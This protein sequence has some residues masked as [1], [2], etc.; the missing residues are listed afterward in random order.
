M[1]ETNV[2]SDKQIRPPMSHTDHIIKEQPVLDRVDTLIER[3][4][5]EKPTIHEKHVQDVLE[6]RET[7]VEKRIIHP[8]QEVF[9]R[10]EDM[11]ETEGKYI[12][13]WNRNQLIESMREQD[14]HH[15]VQV[16]SEEDIHVH[17]QMPTVI[18]EKELT[19]EVLEKPI[20]TEI[21]EQPVREVHD[22]S[23]Y[24]T[25]YEQPSVTVVRDNKVVENIVQD[26]PCR[27]SSTTG[28]VHEHGSTATSLP[29]TQQVIT[30]EIS[31]PV[32]QPTTSLN[33]SVTHRDAVVTQ[34]NPQTQTVIGTT[35]MGQP[36]PHTYV[37]S[38]TMYSTPTTT[39]TAT[40]T[41]KQGLG[42]KLKNVKQKISQKLHRN[43]NT[44]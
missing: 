13:E 28:Y 34:V 8:T 6:V 19:R 27:V 37:P 35:T 36:L 26:Q 21:H 20:V 32:I 33:N 42:A 1:V 31:Q 4:I 9:V 41:Q 5:I 12:A 39:S 3:E 24:R 11:F 43:P 16:T 25:V 29:M 23:L 38:D 22:K 2:R 14:R 15:P 18:Q 7:P 44:A 40:T 30:Q 10:E 17:R